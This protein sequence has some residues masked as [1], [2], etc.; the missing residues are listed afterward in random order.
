MGEKTFI[1]RCQA[2]AVISERW[3][4]RASSPEE[5]PDDMEM[6]A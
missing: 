4:I 2:D 6:P 1:I 3:S 5:A